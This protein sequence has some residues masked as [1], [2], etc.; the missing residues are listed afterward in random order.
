MKYLHAN[1]VWESLCLSVSLSACMPICM[2]LSQPHRLFNMDSAY[3]PKKAFIM[4]PI[5]MYSQL[6]ASASHNVASLVLLQTCAT[7]E[8]VFLLTRKLNL[9]ASMKCL[10]QSHM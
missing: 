9:N 10:L 2:C 3:R 7:F 5:Y 4:L 6:Q 8:H 1:S